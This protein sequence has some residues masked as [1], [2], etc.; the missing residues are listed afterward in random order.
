MSKKLDNIERALER[1][2]LR[3]QVNAIEDSQ[4]EVVLWMGGAGHPVSSVR[5]AIRVVKKLS[6]RENP[7]PN[8]RVTTTVKELKRIY[9]AGKRGSHLK[10]KVSR[11]AKNPTLSTS[12]QAKL[13]S[14][15]KA[16]QSG[17]GVRFD[18]AGNLI[19]PKRRATRRAAPR[20]TKRKNAKACRNRYGQFKTRSPRRRLR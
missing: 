7:S 12:E 11:P 18:S 9:S 19:N 13:E 1:E 4:G 10:L 5:E 15:R 17:K 6:H 2:G 3:N 16:R 20:K 14:W 8:T